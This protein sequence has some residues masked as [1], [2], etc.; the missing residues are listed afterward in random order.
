MELVSNYDRLWQK[1][2]FA[3]AAVREL[4]QG[5]EG[6]AKRI[7]KCE[8]ELTQLTDSVAKLMLSHPTGSVDPT[9]LKKNT[10]TLNMSHQPF[11]D[12]VTICYLPPSA[13]LL[14]LECSML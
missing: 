8:S 9:S 14:Y 7:S 12:T 11:I 10:N 2:G 3:D 6:D 1:T 5:Q 4:E 13:R